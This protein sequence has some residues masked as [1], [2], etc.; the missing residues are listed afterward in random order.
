MNIKELEQRAESTGKAHL[1]YLKA[2]KRRSYKRAR[3]LGFN[4]TQAR[5][6]SGYSIKHIEEF[7]EQQK[8]DLAQ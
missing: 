7:V 8:E 5:I 2:Y 3:E 1:E 4:S 6:L